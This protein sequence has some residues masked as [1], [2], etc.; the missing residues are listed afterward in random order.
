MLRSIRPKRASRPSDASVD[1]TEARKGASQ[2]FGPLHL[3]EAPGDEDCG[4]R[5]ADGIAVLG[6]W[7]G[8][9]QLVH[10]GPSTL[11]S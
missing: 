7:Y 3:G 4:L 11:V 1:H 5:L 10:D 2:E 9:F 8:P 6:R